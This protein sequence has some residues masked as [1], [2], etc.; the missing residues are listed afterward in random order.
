[1]P[2][3]DNMAISPIKTLL[4]LEEYARIMGVTGWHFNQVTHPRQPSADACDVPWFQQTYFY[5]GDKLIGR[6]ELAQAIATAERKIADA[7][8]F[9]PAP[10]WIQ[11]EEHVWPLPKRGVRT[12]YPKFHTDWGY[13]ISAGVERW[14]LVGLYETPIVY[15]D[16]D[17]DG[18]DDWATIN[19]TLGSPYYLYYTNP[20]ACAL[21][22]LAVVPEGQN[23]LDREWRIRPLEVHNLGGGSYR[24]EGPRWMF[25]IPSRIDEHQ[26]IELDDDTAFLQA[27]DVYCHYNYTGNQSLYIWRDYDCSPACGEQTQ[28]A[29]VTVT[30]RRTGQFYA[31][32]ADYAAAT[33]WS[34]ADWPV[35][36]DPDLLRVWYLAGYRDHI[37]GPCDWM[38][39]S[40]KE[41]IVS[42]ANVYLVDSPCG[43]EFSVERWL[44]DREEQ[45]MNTVDVVMAQSMFGT[46]ARGAVMA[47]S[48]VKTIPP[49]GRGG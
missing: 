2:R 43:C 12:A 35:A 3:G 9:W 10:Q 41:A 16:R 34:S 26:E 5:A 36:E 30:E 8:R 19:A 39:A 7:C 20:A 21:C 27:V 42:L 47:Y 49:L 18:V 1:M 33:G 28:S 15:S 40:L 31:Q 14:D 48:F 25:T 45:D 46:T 44:R 6:D 22:E 11:G 37:T 17:N 32:M 29:C 38:G 23:P 13:L 4:P 24:I